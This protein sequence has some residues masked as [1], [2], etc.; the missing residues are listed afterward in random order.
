MLIILQGL[1]L[2]R[3]ELKIQASTQLY[4]ESLVDLLEISSKLYK[5]TTSKQRTPSTESFASDSPMSLSPMPTSPRK[6]R[7]VSVPGLD[8]PA[9]GRFSAVVIDTLLCL[10]VDNPFAVRLFE[11]ASG[12]RVAVELLKRKGLSEAVRCVW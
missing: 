1:F 3:T 11:Q 5:A 2:H 12:L 6:S 8:S 4:V 9:L 10:F 7:S